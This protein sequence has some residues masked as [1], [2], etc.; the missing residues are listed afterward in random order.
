[1]SDRH[2][3]GAPPSSMLRTDPKL[4]SS[5]IIMS[6]SLHPL[7]LQELHQAAPGDTAAPRPL[8]SLQ[9]LK[10][11]PVQLDVM[12]GSAQV[13]VGDLLACREGEV[14]RLD[15]TVEQGVDLMINGHVVARGRLV[16]LDDQFAV[17]LTQ[18]PDLRV[19]G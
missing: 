10:S 2:N 19:G 17:Q 13:T 5:K 7:D 8:T 3:A 14:L 16:A 1:M 9:G 4:P 18:T 12:L 11:L 6:E 15:T